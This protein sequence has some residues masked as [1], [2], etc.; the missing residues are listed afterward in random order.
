[1]GGERE[2]GRDCYVRQGGNGP[3]GE[4]IRQLE[5]PGPDIRKL[6]KKLVHAE[7]VKHGAQN[8]RISQTIS[9]GFP[10][11][12]AASAKERRLKLPKGSA[13]L[14]SVLHPG[15]LSKDFF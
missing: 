2:W 9:R 7:V 11:N 12:E 8:P 3:I 5:G 10:N 15:I 14:L 4:G 13:H 1:M 6:D